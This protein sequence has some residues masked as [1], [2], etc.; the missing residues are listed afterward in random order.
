MAVSGHFSHNRIPLRGQHVTIPAL[1]PGF[2]HKPGNSRRCP[3]E[4]GGRKSGLPDR[5]TGLNG[6]YSGTASI[7]PGNPRVNSVLMKGL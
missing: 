1:F 6:E 4:H 2:R 3:Q 7:H 5:E